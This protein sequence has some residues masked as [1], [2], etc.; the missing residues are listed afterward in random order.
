MLRAC[1]DDVLDPFAGDL[2]ITQANN[3]G[4]CGRV[5]GF[6]D[7]LQLDTITLARH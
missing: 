5:F 4:E 2:I 3:Y 1:S 6:S 7:T